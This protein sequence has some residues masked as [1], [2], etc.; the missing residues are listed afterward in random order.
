MEAASAAP[1]PRSAARGAASRRSCSTPRT[2]RP[3]RSAARSI[4]G[5]Y[6]FRPRRASA[7]MGELPVEKISDHILQNPDVGQ[8]ELARKQER[9][10]VIPGEQGEDFGSA[11]GLQ[12]VLEPELA[13]L[14][15]FLERAEVRDGLQPLNHLRVFMTRSGPLA[16]QVQVMHQGKVDSAIGG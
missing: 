13:A 2:A 11:Y 15:V 14:V 12:P 4:A 5:L 10:R 3:A 7:T 16:S 8:A 1:C 9:E 6:G